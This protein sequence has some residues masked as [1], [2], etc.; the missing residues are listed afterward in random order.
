MEVP[1]LALR[2]VELVSGAP[3]A[4]YG[5]GLAGALDLRTVDPG[6]RPEAQLRWTG[7]GGLD[8]RYDRVSA[9]V[10]TPLRVL[11]LGVVS[12]VD[13]TFDDTWLPALRTPNRRRVLGAPLGWRAENR[14][15]GYLKLAPVEQPRRFLGRGAGEPAGAPAL[16]SRLVA[17]RLDLRARQRQGG[18][19]LQP[20]GAARL[21]ALP[22]GGPPAD[23]RRAAAGRA[24]HARHAGR[25][26][27]AAR[28][29]SAGCARGR[30][31]R[32]AARARRR[33][34]TTG[35]PTVTTWAAT[36]STSCGATTRSTARAAATSSSCARRASSPRGAVTSSGPA[37]GSRTST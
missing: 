37:R 18:A 22:R 30:S 23:H 4:Q 12:A 25:P 34:P 2:N 31:P 19:D 13:G 17:R 32:S 26:P 10:G 20:R 21:P 33:A 15:L 5:C 28:S 7:D 36:P 35:P 3:E 29:A 8:T 11:G 9:R 24:A 27:G 14:M 6:A 1:L 16:R